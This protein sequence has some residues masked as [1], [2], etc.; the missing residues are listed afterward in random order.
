[1]SFSNYNTVEIQ[2]GILAANGGYSST[3]NSLLNCAI[4][5]TTPRTGYGRLQ[6]TRTVTL[7]GALE[8]ALNT[9]FCRPSLIR[10]RF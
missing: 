4:G 1:M 7:K 2:T 9:G 8:V 10:S 3:A 6:A 5:G